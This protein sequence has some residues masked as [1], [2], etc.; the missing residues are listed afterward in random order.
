[1]ILSSAAI[2]CILI[3]YLP[4][5]PHNNIILFDFIPRH[6]V[7]FYVK[8]VTDDLA[9]SRMWNVIMNILILNK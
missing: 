5:G 3:N 8:V 7:K 4:Q 9:E 2:S 6:Y 1:M